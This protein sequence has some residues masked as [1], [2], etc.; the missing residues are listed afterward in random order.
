MV[1]FQNQ[2]LTALKENWELYKTFTNTKT[3]NL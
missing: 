3:E 1:T 2:F